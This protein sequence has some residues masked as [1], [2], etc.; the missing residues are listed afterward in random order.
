MQSSMIN[1]PIQI[2]VP[3]GLGLSKVL[4]S[5]DEKDLL[6]HASLGLWRKFTAGTPGRFRYRSYAGKRSGVPA[7]GPTTLCASPYA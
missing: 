3:T 5:G 6:P 1:V 2:N 4:D 7:N